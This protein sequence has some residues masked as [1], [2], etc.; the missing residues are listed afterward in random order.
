MMWWL[1]ISEKIFSTRGQS[2]E[3]KCQ[4]A[5]KMFQNNV[6]HWPLATAIITSETSRTSSGCL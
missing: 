1:S 2:N 4:K 3:A 6:H 5:V